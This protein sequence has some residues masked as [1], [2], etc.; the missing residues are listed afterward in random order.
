MG[1]LVGVCVALV[2][3]LGIISGRL[4]M[5]LR[6]ARQE[7]GELRAQS[8]QPPEPARPVPATFSAQSPPAAPAR[9]VAEQVAATPVSAATTVSDPPP[10]PPPPPPL[11]QPMVVAPP[12]P[13]ITETLRTSAMLQAD[14]TAAARVT[15]WK[16]RVALSGEPLTTEQLQTL[17]KV[18]SAELRRETEES[19]QLAANAQPVYDVESAIRQR[20]ETLKRQHETNLRILEGMSS[21]LSAF[22]SQALKTQFETGHATRMAAVRADAEQMRQQR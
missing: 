21:H 19:L 11:P 3:A 4:W 18:A 7:L 10:A 12:P 14:Q 20:E 13:V 2:V 17:N 22:Q 1:R 15:M 6:D 8:N 16:D 5:E 9:Q